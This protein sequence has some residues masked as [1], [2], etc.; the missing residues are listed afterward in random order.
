MIAMRVRLEWQ[1]TTTSHQCC[2]LLEYSSEALYGF[3]LRLFHTKGE[4]MPAAPAL[5]NRN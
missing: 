3:S 2:E 5:L 1:W 4:S